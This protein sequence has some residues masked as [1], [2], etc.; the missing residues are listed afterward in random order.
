MPRV[1]VCD[2]DVAMKVW[3]VV[4]MQRYV[5]A[6]CNDCMWLVFTANVYYCGVAEI[7]R[8]CGFQCNCMWLW[9]SSDFMWVWCWIQ[10]YVT[11]VQRRQLMTVTS[12]A[13]VCDCYVPVTVYDCSWEWF[14]CSTMRLWCSTESYVTGVTTLGVWCSSHGMGPCTSV[15]HYPPSCLHVSDAVVSEYDCVNATVI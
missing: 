15:V 9:C 10:V 12:N 5:T 8:D 14:K 1:T 11:L 7:L 4:L 13:A 2:Y 6:G 3:L